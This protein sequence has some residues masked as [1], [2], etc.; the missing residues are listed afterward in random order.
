VLDIPA[1]GRP[2]TYGLREQRIAP[3]LSL[4]YVTR[5]GRE[6]LTFGLTYLIAAVVCAVALP[7]GH[8]FSPLA[9]AAALLFA[10]TLLFN[11]R[12]AAT[13]WVACTQAAFVLL[14]FVLPLNLVTRRYGAALLTLPPSL[15]PRGIRQLTL[16]RGGRFRYDARTGPPAQTAPAPPTRGPT[17]V[18]SEASRSPARPTARGHCGRSRAS[19][20]S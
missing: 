3:D 9:P 14:V 17:C 13:G 16:Q 4:D 10:V 5:R 12:V 8:P 7:A 11:L 2:S 1:I 18:H 20:Q 15:R 6:R 19:G